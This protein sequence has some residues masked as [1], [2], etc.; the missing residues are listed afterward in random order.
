[1]GSCEALLP[2]ASRI[3]EGVGDERHSR[4]DAVV[5]QPGTQAVPIAEQVRA[6]QGQLERRWR[7]GAGGGGGRRGV[8]GTGD[9]R[10]IEE[11]RHGDEEEHPG[12]RPS[13]YWPSFTLLFDAH[14]CAFMA[15]EE[16][17]SFVCSCHRRNPPTKALALSPA[18]QPGG[19]SCS[20][21]TLPPPKT[22]YSG[23]RAAMRRAIT[24]A[25]SC[26]HFFLPSRLYPRTPT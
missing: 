17:P 19:S 5:L 24:S 16:L 15:V 22:T 11:H 6:G 8:L 21:L 7:Q 20:L 12:G 10:P 9:S 1:M 23:S 26:R 2:A 25:T 3:A 14:G 4:R 13:L 18:R